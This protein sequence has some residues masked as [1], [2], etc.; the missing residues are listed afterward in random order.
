MATSSPKRNESFSPWLVRQLTNACQQWKTTEINPVPLTWG[1]SA[2]VS[3]FVLQQRADAQSLPRVKGK[4][5]HLP[6]WKPCTQEAVASL[7]KIVSRLREDWSQL[8]YRQTLIL[9][10]RAIDYSASAGTVAPLWQTIAAD[11]C[12]QIHVRLKCKHDKPPG[13]RTVWKDAAD[14]AIKVRPK[15]TMATTGY[16]RGTLLEWEIAY[17]RTL[18]GFQEQ[19]LSQW[20]LTARQCEQQIQRQLPYHARKKVC[21]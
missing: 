21:A 5:V 14:S 2:E 17:R 16:M 6:G 7:G 4:G 12:G 13:R 19:E 9:N 20:F 8:E 18:Q 1:A 15:L 3:T 11:Q 10:R